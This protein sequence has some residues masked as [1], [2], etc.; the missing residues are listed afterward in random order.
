[1]AGN[2]IALLLIVWS[3][4]YYFVIWDFDKEMK[5]NNI[6]FKIHDGT[7]QGKMLLF[8]ISPLIALWMLWNELKFALITLYVCLPNF[9]KKNDLSKEDLEKMVNEYLKKNDDE[10]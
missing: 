10:R 2:I 4:S 6:P 5:K 8:M 9:G 1:M 3:A 7:L